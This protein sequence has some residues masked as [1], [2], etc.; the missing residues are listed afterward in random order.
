MKWI[1]H[2]Q[3][4]YKCEIVSLDMAYPSS[5]NPATTYG[6]WLHSLKVK[7]DGFSNEWD[8]KKAAKEYL[9]THPAS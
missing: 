9:D 4:S 3:Y 7:K 2:W 8:A 5:K 6:Y 1:G